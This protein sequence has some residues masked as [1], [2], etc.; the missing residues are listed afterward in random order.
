MSTSNQSMT[1][2]DDIKSKI[3]RGVLSPAESLREMD[4]AEQ[5]GV[6]RNTVKKVLLML[7]RD[8][9]VTI[10]RNKGAKVRSY[11]MKEVLDFSSSA[12]MM[13]GFIARLAAAVIPMPDR[14]AAEILALMKGCKEHNDLV[15]Y[16]QHNQLF[17]GVIYDACPN[18]VTVNLLLSLKAQMKKYNTKT[19]L[20]PGRSDLSFAEHSAIFEAMLQRNGDL[21]E[22]L[23]RKH[24]DNVRAAFKDNYKLLLYCSLSHLQKNTYLLWIWCLHQLHFGSRDKMHSH[25]Y[26][27]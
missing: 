10:E 17:H 1:V 14:P 3:E 15:S 16:S 8:K 5:Y 9:L 19:I 2:Y 22:L 6:S 13:E 20:V 27:A 25:V 12:S 23:M 21:A 24:I 18:L 26:G 11:S 7:E 4:L